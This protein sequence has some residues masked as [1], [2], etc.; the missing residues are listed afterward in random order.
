[1]YNDKIDAAL[2][3]ATIAHG[4]Q[5]RSYTG[6]DYIT[7]PIAVRGI[8][9]LYSSFCSPEMEMAALLH[10]T[11]E[12]T[13]ATLYDIETFFGPKVRDLVGWL[14]DVATLKDGNRATR[15]AMERDKL[16]KAPKVAKT[17][18]LAD[19]IHNTGSIVSCDPNFAKVYMAEKKLLLEVLKE[20]D[21]TLY[22]RAS[23]QVEQY[24]VNR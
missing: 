5:K 13:Q 6:E 18:K 1:M 22:K 4:E 12:D 16:L 11:V 3:F 8:L 23:D 17:I 7:H 9:K 20:G 14:T 2:R 19:L 24:Y 10:D 21:E 15:K